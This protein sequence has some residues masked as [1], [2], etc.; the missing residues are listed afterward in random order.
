MSVR[1]TILPWIRMQEISEHRERYLRM[2]PKSTDDQID[3]RDQIIRRAAPMR[4][5]LGCREHYT[6]LQC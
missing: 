2:I 4:L 6:T 3:H 5:A 1:A